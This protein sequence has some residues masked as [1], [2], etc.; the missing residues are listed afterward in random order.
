[1]VDS[2]SH[3][4]GIFDSGVGGISVANAIKSAMPAEHLIYVADSANAPYGNKSQS[5]ILSR[6]QRIVEFLL[7]QKVKLIVVACNT[8]TLSCIDIL[9]QQYSLPFVGVEPGV[10]PAV[11]ATLSKKVGVL[12]TPLT[13]Q[14]E[15]YHQLVERVAH[16]VEVYS[17]GCDGLA[18]PIEKGEFDSDIIISLVRGFV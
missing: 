6:S 13:V 5:F 18:F 7:A 14:S 17:Q 12:A 10:K 8:A 15:R 3:P 9:R 2:N 11:A 16:G 4:I 1:M